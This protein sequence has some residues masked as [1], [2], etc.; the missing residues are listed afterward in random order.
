MG[1]TLKPFQVTLVIIRGKGASSGGKKKKAKG[2]DKTITT[3]PA[4]VREIWWGANL[5]GVS[6]DDPLQGLGK[7]KKRQKRPAQKVGRFKDIGEGIGGKRTGEVA[8]TLRRRRPK[9]GA[10]LTNNARDTRS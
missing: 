3:T 8:A 5:Q 10:R 2:R 1:H 6:L 4:I 9:G 7:R